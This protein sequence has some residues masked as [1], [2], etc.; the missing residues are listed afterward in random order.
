MLIEHSGPGKY[1]LGA[2]E[3]APEIIAHLLRDLSDKEADFRP[4]AKRFTLREMM[5]HLADWEPIFLARLQRTRD[6]DEPF[7]TD[8]DEGKLALEH[9]YAHDYAHSDLV[10]HLRLFT[11][12]R[13][14]MVAFTRDLAPAAWQQVCHHERAGRLTLEGLVTLIVLHDAYHLRQVTQWREQYSQR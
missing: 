10:E 3:A 11:Q 6:E 2:L 13:A 8:V 12:C 9:D 4:D 14:Q 1:L 5:A 7:L